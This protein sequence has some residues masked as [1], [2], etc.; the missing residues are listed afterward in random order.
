MPERP[1]PLIVAF[2]ALVAAGAL[3]WFF[4]SRPAPIRPSPFEEEP[5]D[6]LPAAETLHITNVGAYHEIDAAY[7]SRTPLRESA[8]GAAD[9]AAVALMKTF[10]EKEVSRF[11]ENS[12]DT[13]T[14]ED[15]RVQH[16][17]G[18]RKYV[19]SAEYEMRESASTVSYIYVLYADTLGAHP[20]AYYRT[21]T[22]DKKTGESLHLDDLFADDSYLETLSEKSRESLRETLGET[23]SPDM[24]EAGT[25]PF[26][27]NFG[28]FY[29]EG[30]VLALIFPPYQVGPWAIGTQEVRIPLS[31]LTGM[32]APEYR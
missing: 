30:T 4:L 5:G 6:E 12:V 11:K 32:L 26:S 20:N 29:L 24:L 16:L 3:L 9:T 27:D 7:P 10:A 2:L 21:F 13:I 1:L 28:N 22:F 8:G 31:E 15:V 18:E 19:L 14:E 25:T 17:G 23:A